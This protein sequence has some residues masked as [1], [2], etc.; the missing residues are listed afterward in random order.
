[1]RRCFMLLFILAVLVIC[2]AACG[3]RMLESSETAQMEQSGQTNHQTEQTTPAEQG[4]ENDHNETD[5]TEPAKIF[6]SWDEVPVNKYQE[7]TIEVDYN[8][9]TIWGIAYIPE[10]GQEK[11]P[12]V[13]CSHG[14][15]GSYTSCMEYAE[16][17]ASH[18]IATYCFDFRGG[19]GN[20]SD[21]RITKMSLITEATD[22]QTIIA[23]AKN[24]DFVDPEKIILL[25]ESQ[26]G[27]ASAIAAARSKDDVNGLIL[28][29]PAFL[30]HDA[31]HER[32][33]S[34]DEIPDSYFFEWLTLGKRYAED[35]WD[36]D[37]Y[38][39]I[40][41]YTKAVLLMHG[42]RDNI[43]P[44]SYAEKAAETYANVEYHVINGGGHGFYG[45]AL[46]NAFSY[47]LNFLQK[48]RIWGE[49]Q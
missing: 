14:L 19:G 39:E 23:A 41:N 29:Y 45:P 37:V 46:D 2:L 6:N 30:V 28:C 9:Q 12:L 42:D 4:Q 31:V 44:I 35:V 43:V 24:W 40:G 8:G 34:P 48:I 1:M 10:T 20:H 22:V 17:L 36:Y 38:A 27:A 11:F 7:K 32:F 18:G 16:L 47:I 3:Q 26:G 49:E 33:D 21:G 13:I 5:S 15:G 25:G